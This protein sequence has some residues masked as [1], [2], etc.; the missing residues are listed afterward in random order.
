MTNPIHLNFIPPGKYQETRFEKI[1]N[2]TVIS[3]AEGARL[4][5]EEIANRIR[6]CIDRSYS[7]FTTW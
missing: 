4:V 3:E 6:N 5:A 2:I 1:H 7:D